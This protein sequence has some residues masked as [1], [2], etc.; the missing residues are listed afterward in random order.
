MPNNAALYLRGA[1]LNGVAARTQISVGPRAFIN[2]MAVRAFQLSV[3]AKQF[4]GDL[5]E[6]LVQFAPK[7]FLDR[8]F[9][10]RYTGRADAAESAHLVQAHDLDLSVT[11]GQLLAHD[12]ILRRSV[13][14]F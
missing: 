9:R 6:A 10:A 14:V 13:P 12:W 7:D 4:L 1:C 8:P 11:L 3:G 5:L 2:C